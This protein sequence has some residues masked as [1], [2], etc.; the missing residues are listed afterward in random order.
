MRIRKINR[1]INRQSTVHVS[2]KKEDDGKGNNDNNNDES[3]EDKGYDNDILLNCTDN[4]SFFFIVWLN[5]CAAST[6][7]I[8]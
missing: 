1:Y 6:N 8:K 3:N 7:V 2:I 4:I 5:L